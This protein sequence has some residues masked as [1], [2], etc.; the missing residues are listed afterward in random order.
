MT[1]ELQHLLLFGLPLGSVLKRESKSNGLNFDWVLT[2]LPVS[3]G[4]ASVFNSGS[5]CP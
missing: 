4:Q 5:Q 3:Y 2:S 1:L